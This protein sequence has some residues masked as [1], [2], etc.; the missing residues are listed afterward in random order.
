MTL[1]KTSLRSVVSGLTSLGMVSGWSAAFGVA[2]IATATPAAACNSEPYIGSICTFAF[3]YCPQGYAQANGQV[4]PIDQNQILYTLL[5]SRY[6]G[7]GRANFALPDFRGRSA[8]GKGQGLGL[9]EIFLAE[10]VGQQ[11]IVLNENQVPLR[12]HTH[13]ATFTGTGGESTPVYIP[14]SA[15]SLNVTSKLQALQVTGAAQPQAGLFL[16]MGGGGTQQAPI[17]A[18]STATTTAVEL[19][20]LEVKL[21]GT[22]GHGAVQF[23]VDTGITGG[24]VSVAAAGMSPSATVSTQSPAIG[25]TVCIATTGL[26]PTRP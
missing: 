25:M 5:G 4:L 15:G 13:S 20:G 3:D 1:L 23:D 19:G 24:I 2:A 9:G 21:T 16:G 26:Y 6:G 11:T 22:A 18:T 8:I 7:D 10:Q 17:Y 14:P 12:A